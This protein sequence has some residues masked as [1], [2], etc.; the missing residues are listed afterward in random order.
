MTDDLFSYANGHPGWKGRGTSFAA[1]VQ[2]APKAPTLRDRVLAEVGRGAGTP[3]D[4]CARLGIDILAGRPRFSELAKAGKIRDSGA[5]G[6][7]RSGGKAI[8]WEAA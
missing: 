5:R 6:V 3:E 7:S 1:A 4:I 2:I 8:V